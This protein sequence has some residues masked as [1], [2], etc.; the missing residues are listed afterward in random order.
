MICPHC[1][2]EMD[3]RSEVRRAHERAGILAH[4]ISIY[5]TVDGNDTFQ[6]YGEHGG[7][8]SRQVFYLTQK[9]MD[10]EQYVLPVYVGDELDWIMRDALRQFASEARKVLSGGDL[11]LPIEKENAK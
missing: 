10:G 2:Q 5:T 7:I 8:L 11:G 1:K 9:R 3:R 6:V 4:G